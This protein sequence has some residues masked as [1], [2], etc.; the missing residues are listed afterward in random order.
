LELANNSFFNSA[1]SSWTEE[2]SSSANC[3]K[4]KRGNNSTRNI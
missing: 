4:C 2:F 1:R 3:E